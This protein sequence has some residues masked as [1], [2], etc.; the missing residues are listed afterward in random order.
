[1][2]RGHRVYKT[3]KRTLII[4]IL[5]LSVFLALILLKIDLRSTNIFG[6]TGMATTEF[7]A[8]IA[9]SSN[10]SAYVADI[11]FTL[12]DTVYTANESIGFKGYLYITNYSDNGSLVSASAPLASAYVNLTIK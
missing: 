1:M 4:S 9:S 7:Y 12:P 6:M 8:G 3:D 10:S 11:Y 5:L 2:K